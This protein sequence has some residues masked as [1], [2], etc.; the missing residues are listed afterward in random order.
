VG[1]AD[2]YKSGDYNGVCDFC[3]QVYKFSQLKKNW[4][5]QWVCHKDFEVRHP[6]DF[7]RGVEDKQSVPERSPE[8]P[9][10]FVDEVINLP[11]PPQLPEL[12]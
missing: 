1:R 8:S 12:D 9:D 7:V 4:L 11:L 10:V 2:Y 5:G 6:Q 3:G